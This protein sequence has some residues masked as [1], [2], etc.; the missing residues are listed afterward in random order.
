MSEESEPKIAHDP[1][2]A[3][4]EQKQ[5]T[6]QVSH[7]AERLANRLERD[8]IAVLFQ[9]QVY[10]FDCSDA[11]HEKAASHM[12]YIAGGGRLKVPGTLQVVIKALEHSLAA[13]KA[14]VQ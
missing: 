9:I 4:N 11:S 7:E 13:L 3:C 8:K 5:R 12:D 6:R 10:G 14:Q 1:A 2:G